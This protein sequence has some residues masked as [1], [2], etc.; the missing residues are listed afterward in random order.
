METVSANHIGL[1]V[2]A[3]GVI[4]TMAVLIKQLFTRTPA[5]HQEFAS[6]EEVTTLTKKLDTLETT[7]DENFKDLRRERSTSTANLHQRIEQ[8]DQKNQQITQELRKE[9]KS[10][11]GGVHD[12]LTQLLQAFSEFRGEIKAEIKSRHPFP[13]SKPQ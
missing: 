4:L 5:L 13:G 3:L 12:R 10:D 6:R 11:F 1:F 8:F 7:V 9:T 2:G